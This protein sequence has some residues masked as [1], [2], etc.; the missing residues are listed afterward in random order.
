M[1]TTEARLRDGLQQLAGEARPSVGVPEVLARAARIQRRRRARQLVA[2]TAAAVTAGLLGWVVLAPR[3]VTV[4][5]APLATPS[6][7]PGVTTAVFGFTTGEPAI[8]RV[9][10][11]RADTAADQVRL[12]VTEEIA[13]R[14]D[15]VRQH[16]YVAAPG[17]LFTTTVRTGL[18]VTLIP[19]V[20]RDAQ[21]SGPIPGQ[22]RR[23]TDLNTGVTLAASWDE[24]RGRDAQ[25]IW[26]GSDG[27]VRTAPDTVLPSAGLTVGDTTLTVYRNA[28]RRDIEDGGWGVFGASGAVSP[29]VWGSPA[30]TEVRA[31]LSNVAQRASVGM[32]PHGASAVTITPAERARWTVGTMPDGSVWYLVLSEAEVS[33]DS[34]THR[35]VRS[36]GYTDRTGKRVSYQ[37]RLST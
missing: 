25:L 28:G 14:P 15:D 36:I 9:I 32:L 33:S 3:P 2:A 27:L 21:L 24:G 8:R 13:G 22:L 4:Q 10:T 18:T 31:F 16:T 5:P 37:P 23:W 6:V 30:G 35:L 34:S 20:V 7:R 17:R 19:D 1:T 26:I 29:I 12:T 11:V